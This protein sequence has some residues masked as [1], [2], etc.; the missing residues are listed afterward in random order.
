MLIPLHN[1]GLS[2]LCTHVANLEHTPSFV[3]YKHPP[4]APV[5][6]PL[7]PQHIIHHDWHNVLHSSRVTL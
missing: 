6:L 2:S 5:H 4:L 3:G 1:L 7:H